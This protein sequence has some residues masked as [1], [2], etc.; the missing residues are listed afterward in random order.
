MKMPRNY[1]L[2]VIWRTMDK[3]DKFVFLDG[4][5]QYF[6][7]RLKLERLGEGEYELLITTTDVYRPVEDFLVE[8]AYERSLREL[9][10]SLVYSYYFDR[11]QGYEN[12]DK[13]LSEKA[14]NQLE[15]R[16]KILEQKKVTHLNQIK[17]NYGNEQRE[18]SE[19]IQEV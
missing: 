11:L 7:P 10:D 12:D 14:M 4:S 8:Y 1:M 13:E 3:S 15:D 17:E 9:S 16:V 2:S 18:N 19:A 5:E 6:L